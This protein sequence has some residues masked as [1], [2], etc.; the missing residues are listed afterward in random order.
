MPENNC[1]LLA[2]D[3]AKWWRKTNREVDAWLTSLFGVV[4]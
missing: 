3:V 1:G 4:N 2:G